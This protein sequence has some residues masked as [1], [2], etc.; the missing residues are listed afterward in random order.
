MIKL[1]QRDKQ[2]N[3]FWHRLKRKMLK[4]SRKKSLI[5]NLK[6]DFLKFQRK[7]K[8]PTFRVLALIENH[9]KEKD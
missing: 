6:S 4:R 7:R 5:I 3:K 9:K 1:F 2:K 8:T